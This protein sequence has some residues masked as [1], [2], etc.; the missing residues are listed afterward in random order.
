MS[1]NIRQLITDSRE[2]DPAE[3]TQFEEQLKIEA[4]QMRLK[5]TPEHITQIAKELTLRGI[6][7]LKDYLNSKSYPSIPRRKI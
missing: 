4:V 7:T 3:L 5:L 2:H 1:L 6:K